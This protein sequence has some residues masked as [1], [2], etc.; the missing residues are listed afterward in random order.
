MASIFLSGLRTAKMGSPKRKTRVRNILLS[1]GVEVT[2][3]NVAAP[4]G[5]NLV[6][7]VLQNKTRPINN[8]N[9]YSAL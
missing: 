1:H 8:R 7:V 2:N 3:Q 5:I 4:S 9:I 6:C